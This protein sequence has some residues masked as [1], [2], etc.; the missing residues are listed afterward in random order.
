MRDI[1][2]RF[3]IRRF[4]YS[5]LCLAGGILVIAAVYLMLCLNVDDRTLK[6]TLGLLNTVLGLVFLTVGSIA[7]L[8]K[9]IIKQQERIEKLEEE[10]L[11]LKRIAAVKN[12]E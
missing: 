11:E 12:K 1:F 7:S 5:M 9:F 8:A 2:L 6:S 10:V 3:D 4:R